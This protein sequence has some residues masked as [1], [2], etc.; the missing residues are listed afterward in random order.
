MKFTNKTP[1][2][3][4]YFIVDKNKDS[5]TIYRESFGAKD[6]KWTIMFGYKV[7]TADILDLCSRATE[8]KW[9]MTMMDSYIAEKL[10]FIAVMPREI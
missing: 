6:F 1:D 9:P 8:E 4:Y 3:R 7:D 5:G 2:V 10:K